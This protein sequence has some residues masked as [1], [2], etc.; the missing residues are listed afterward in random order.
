MKKK[1]FCL[2]F[3][4]YMLIASFIKVFSI[5]KAEVNILSN[6]DYLKLG[7]EIEITIFIKNAKLIAYNFELFF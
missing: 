3:I 1:I 2:I 7:E 4:F 6:K 5:E